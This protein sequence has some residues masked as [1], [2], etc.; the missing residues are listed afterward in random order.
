MMDDVAL[1][2][3]RVPTID[4]DVWIVH[5]RAMIQSVGA[6]KDTLGDSEQAKLD[7]FFD[8]RSSRVG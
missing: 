6:G 1:H 7:E 2:W 5:S 4:I 8:V 3:T